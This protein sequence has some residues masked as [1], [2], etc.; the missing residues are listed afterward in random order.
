ML[1]GIIKGSVLSGRSEKLKT[2]I[3]VGNVEQIQEN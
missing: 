2:E 1:T 3:D